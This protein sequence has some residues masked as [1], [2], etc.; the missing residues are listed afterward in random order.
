MKIIIILLIVPFLLQGC[1]KS[2]TSINSSTSSNTSNLPIGQSYQGGMIAYI[3]Q[4]GDIGYI[5]GETHG[6]IAAPKDYIGTWSTTV[7]LLS[8]LKVELK[9]VDS[10]YDNSVGLAKVS[11][12]RIVNQFTYFG[13]GTANGTIIYPTPFS[14]QTPYAAKLCDTLVL[15]GYSDW[16]LPTVSELE[17]MNSVQDKI[18][19]K[20]LSKYWSSNTNYIGTNLSNSGIYIY[21]TSSRAGL[22]GSI[23]FDDRLIQNYIR[24]IRYF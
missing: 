2:G 24:P 1:N 9:V 15:N 10:V 16:W 6:I 5:S 23:Q 14:Y 4:K 11:T 13:T 17:I 18:A 12:Q 20:S 7:T 3:F 21:Y 8:N 19:L 22:N